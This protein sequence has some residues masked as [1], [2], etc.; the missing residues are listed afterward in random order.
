MA[1]ICRRIYAHAADQ[2]AALDA[3]GPVPAANCRSPSDIACCKA[4]EPSSLSEVYLL[5]GSAGP[6]P[7]VQ[8]DI[9][10]GFIEQSMPMTTSD[11]RDRFLRGLELAG[12][13]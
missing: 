7:Q 1:T 6:L 8:P 10:I 5:H 13:D 12:M 2:G 4:I 11:A 9:S 3:A